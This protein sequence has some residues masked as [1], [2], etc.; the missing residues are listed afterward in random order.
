MYTVGYGEYIP[1]TILSRLL[2]AT[3]SVL[4]VGINSMLMVS[5]FNYLSMSCQETKSLSLTHRLE[6]RSKMEKKAGEILA[7][8][9]AM[10]D[11]MSNSPL[12]P[13]TTNRLK[14]GYSTVKCDVEN[15]KK[16]RLIIKN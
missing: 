3:L 1:K 13:E 12:E 11:R 8:I 2:A 7:N 10:N 15:I 16:Y 14:E 5:V 6:T 4:G 9:T